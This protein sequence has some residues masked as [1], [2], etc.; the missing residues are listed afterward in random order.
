M[1]YKK[2]LFL[3]AINFLVF[4]CG[5]V[6]ADFV[7]GF[8]YNSATINLEKTINNNEYTATKITRALNEHPGLP[9]HLLSPYFGWI[10]TPRTTLKSALDPVRITRQSEKEHDPDWLYIPNNNMGFVSNY[11]IPLIKKHNDVLILVLGGSVARWFALQSSKEFISQLGRHSYFKDKNIILLNSASGGYKQPQQLNLLNFLII[12]S[13]IPDIVI[14][15]DGFN[16]AALSYAN[17][18]NGI[19]P[20]YPSY[21]HWAHLTHGIALAPEIRQTIKDYQDSINNKDYFL[22]LYRAH[23]YSNILSYFFLKKIDHWNNEVRRHEVIYAKKVTKLSSKAFEISTRGPMYDVGLE[24]IADIWVKS[25]KLMHDISI[26]NGIQYFHFLQPTAHD[27]D[28][29]KT[30]TQEETK[31]IG[32]KN[33]LWAQGVRKLYPMFKSRAN[34]LKESG[35][36]YKDLTNIFLGIEDTLYYDICHFNQ[37]GNDL[38]AKAIANYILRH[39]DESQR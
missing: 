24:S 30:L 31:L 19:S 39:T 8:I 28:N 36:L 38:F 25:S 5:V 21:S 22:S 29:N 12:S 17:L 15:I 2:K 9:K 14:D 23:S 13:T 3:I 35:I 34:E 10:E 20:I 37:K 16:E 32:E 18:A 7:F 26:R 27:P 4:I 33:H 1:N 6:G 11:D